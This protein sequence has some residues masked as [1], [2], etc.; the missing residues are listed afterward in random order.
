[1]VQLD[2]ATGKRIAADS[3]LY[4]LAWH[5]SIEA[6][7]L[8]ESHGWY[9]LFVNWGLYCRGVNSTYEIRIGRSANITGPYLDKDGV[10]LLQGGG[11]LFLE[12]DG[13]YI[14]PG[15]AGV[16]SEGRTNW[17]SYHFYDGQNSGLATL[18]LRRLGWSTN[19]WPVI[20]NVRFER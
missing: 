8:F 20:E 17:L 7:C 6:P 19:G 2:P 11:S 10:D 13:R 12:T 5:N 9:Y 18:R 1:M 15:H 16:Y 3:P 4:S 14:G